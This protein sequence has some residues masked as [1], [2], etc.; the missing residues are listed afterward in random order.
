[1]RFLYLRDP[2][3]LATLIVYVVNREVLKPQLGWTFCTDYLND[4]ICIPFLVPV[5]LWLARAMRLRR[6]DEAPLAHEI[7][8]PL[9][10]WSMAFEVVLP[11]LPEF[12]GIAVADPMDV[13]CYCLG[14]MLGAVFWRHRYPDQIPESLGKHHRSD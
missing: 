6:T 14:A 4:C 9:I 12:R 11:V 7:L 13:A 8:I 3:F 10:V 5:M 2:L 1:M